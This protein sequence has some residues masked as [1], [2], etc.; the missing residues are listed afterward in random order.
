MHAYRPTACRPAV[1]KRTWNGGS[2]ARRVAPRCAVGTSSTS[3]SLETYYANSLLPGVDPNAKAAVGHRSYWGGL[4][5]GGTLNMLAG[6]PGAGKSS[7][8]LAMGLIIVA[9]GSLFGE[10]LPPT[11]H[12]MVDEGFYAPPRLL[13]LETEDR[14]VNIDSMINQLIALGVPHTFDPDDQVSGWY[15]VSLIVKS[16]SKY[17]IYHCRLLHSLALCLTGQGRKR[18]PEVGPGPVP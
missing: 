17:Y 15:R 8:A 1:Q 12:I 14:K 18:G 2:P 11:D 9:G 16:A 4:L 6:A 3:R 10:T 7:I 5:S 13:V